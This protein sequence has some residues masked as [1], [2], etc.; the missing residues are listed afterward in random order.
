MSLR[1]VGLDGLNLG[2][3]SKKDLTRM[4][5]SCFIF[6]DCEP[7]LPF[8]AWKLPHFVAAWWRY[9]LTGPSLTL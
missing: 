1:E 4:L 9:S 2:G 8:G 6:A 7:A 5:R 3:L